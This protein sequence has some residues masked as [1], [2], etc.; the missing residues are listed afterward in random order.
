MLPKKFKIQFGI[1]RYFFSAAILCFAAYLYTE[2]HV[3][4][5]ILLGP[6]I[7]LASFTVSAL[8]NLLQIQI[9]NLDLAALL[10]ATLIYFCFTGF[11]IK[12]LLQERPMRR[13]LTLTGLIG[14]LGYLHLL[15]WQ[16]LSSYL[17]R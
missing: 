17:G 4:F 15:A 9:A 2:G 6:P 1:I 16:N 11:L 10:P 3:F 5:L 13:Y 14:F 7:H 8:E 12:Q